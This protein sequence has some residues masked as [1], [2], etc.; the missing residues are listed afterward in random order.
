MSNK[1]STFGV[2]KIYGLFFVLVSFLLISSVYWNNDIFCT[3]EYE[4][5]CWEK[6]KVLKTYPNKCYLQA[7][8]AKFMYN[9]KC[10]TRKYKKLTKSM[11][12][13]IDKLV[14]KFIIKLNK[15]NLTAEKKLEKIEKIIERIKN[16]RNKKPK[17][18]NI[19]NYLWTKLEA[20]KTTFRIIIQSGH[21]KESWETF[22]EKC[23][24]LWWKWSHWEWITWVWC[25]FWYSAKNVKLLEKQCK[26]FDWEFTT[27]WSGCWFTWKE[28]CDSACTILCKFEKKKDIKYNY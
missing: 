19:L 15:T 14:N 4:P 18:S 13:K 12:L 9:W 25:N 21:S 5:V 28:I 24:A 7:A 23:I 6:Q 27:C 22:E 26:I 8:N 10:E 20:E 2:K 1:T 3:Q 17:L 11:E 16:L